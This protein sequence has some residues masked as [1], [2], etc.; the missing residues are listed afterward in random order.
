MFQITIQSL[1]YYVIYTQFIEFRF[2]FPRDSRTSSVYLVAFPGS[3]V[4]FLLLL[5]GEGN[6]NNL[7]FYSRRSFYRFVRAGQTKH[8]GQSFLTNRNIVDGNPTPPMLPTL[9]ETSSHHWRRLPPTTTSP[10]WRFSW[11][12]NSRIACWFPHSEPA[13]WHL[14]GMRARKKLQRT[15]SARWTLEELARYTPKST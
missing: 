8:W 4:F 5:T 9:A 3:S 6:R 13:F 14:R 11:A 1:F 10:Y 15:S 7:L 12:G 2:P